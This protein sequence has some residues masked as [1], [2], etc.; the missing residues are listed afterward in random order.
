MDNCI[1][2]Y[3]NPFSLS[4]NTIIMKNNEKI[5]NFLSSDPNKLANELIDLAYSMEIYD[6]KIDT[7]ADMAQGIIE[8][9]KEQ[10][11]KNFINNKI[12]IEVI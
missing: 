2:V 9:V 8:L 10:E 7:S 4:S 12:K 11:S 1:I 3:L 5:S 6:I